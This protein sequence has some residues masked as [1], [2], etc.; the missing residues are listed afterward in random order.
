VGGESK[1]AQLERADIEYA[2]D[3]GERFGDFYYQKTIDGSDV[4]EA[5]GPV[6]HIYV[7]DQF[8]KHLEPG[9]WTEPGPQVIVNGATPVSEKAV[10]AAEQT[11]VGTQLAK[12]L[13]TEVVAEWN[14][15]DPRI[16]GAAVKVG[17]GYVEFLGQDLESEEQLQVFIK[18]FL[19][20]T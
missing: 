17:D 5:G 19:D 10:A 1:V 11:T 2:R 3:T 16:F 13:G 9:Q 14:P 12:D 20:A 7:T 6:M 18:E 15:D 8:K 4:T